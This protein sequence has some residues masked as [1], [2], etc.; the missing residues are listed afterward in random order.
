M[1]QHK[2]CEKRIRS[3][4]KAN[5]RNRMRRSNMRTAVRTVLD[6]KN[7]ETA[8]KALQKAV[9]VLDKSVKTNIIHRN[10]AANKKAM[11]YKHVKNLAK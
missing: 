10:T 2:S 8:G 11:L 6:A 3:S 1:P 7:G 5:L 4:R 9:S